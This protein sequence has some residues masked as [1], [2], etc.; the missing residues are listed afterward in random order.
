MKGFFVAGTDTGVGKTQVAGAL[1]SLLADAGQR[2]CAFK[3]YESGARSLPEDARWLRRCAG[4]WQPMD[5][6]CLHRFRAPLAPGVAA[7]REG[8]S[9][10][11]AK[12]LGV[13]RSF[14]TPVVVEG[15]GGL[16]VPLD[17]RHEVIDLAAALKLPVVLVARAGLGTLNHVALSLDALRARRLPVA[18]VVLIKSSAGYDLSEVDN[19]DWLRKRH[20]VRVLGPLKFLA[21]QPRRHRALKKLLAPV[22]AP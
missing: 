20:R 15:A 21:S 13:F 9:P 11:W 18:A 10:S 1:L 5:S 3:P 22:L 19:P 12:T 2:P 17:A 7:A 16:R 4:D 6:V 8:R 14:S